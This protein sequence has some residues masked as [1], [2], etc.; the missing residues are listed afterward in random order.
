M[1]KYIESLEKAVKNIHIADH[2]LYV[3]YPVIKDK[4]LLM[5]TLEQIYDS[6]VGI[7]NSI[8][9]YDYMYKRISLYSD[10]RANFETFVN[11]C[12]K[13][14]NITQEE[15]SEIQALMVLASSHKKSSME[16]MRKEKIVIMTNNLKTAIV[17]SE[18]LKKSLNLAKNLANKVKLVINSR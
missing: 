17:D 7:I 5:K 18:K 13:R 6:V 8:L 2:M 14:Y 12:A 9:Q 10:P 1:E 4:R 3:T 15:L 11:K 16:F